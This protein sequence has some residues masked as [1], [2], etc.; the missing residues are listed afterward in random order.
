MRTRARASAA[1]LLLAVMI[2]TAIPFSVSAA[3]TVYNISIGGLR[4][5]VA[6]QTAVPV[7]NANAAPG[8]P[9]MY[10][11]V[12]EETTWY[13][14]AGRP[15]ENPDYR[16]DAGHVYGLLLTLETLGDRT[17][18][19][20][21]AP[22][23]SDENAAN[24]HVSTH[25]FK[26]NIARYRIEF[27][28]PG[29]TEYTPI[30]KI[31]LS[32]VAAPMEGEER[33]YHTPQL[34]YCNSYVFRSSWSGKFDS[35]NRFL[36]GEEYTYSVL[37]IAVEGYSF[38]ASDMIL[39][40]LD[41]KAPDSVR[42]YVESG[43]AYCDISFKYKVSGK[44]L[45]S[46]IRSE[47][48]VPYAGEMPTEENSK[49]LSIGVRDENA[50][51]GAN[52]TICWKKDKNSY[53]Y[54]GRFKFGVF[55]EI[56][57]TYKILNPESLSFTED[58]QLCLANRM[59]WTAKLIKYTADSVTFSVRVRACFRPDAGYYSD[60][61]VYCYSFEDLKGALENPDY[62]YVL[63]NG[64][65]Y[66]YTELLNGDRSYHYDNF[67]SREKSGI[68]VAGKKVL[69]LN[70]E[71]NFSPYDYNCPEE[72]IRVPYG[73]ELELN[74][75]GKMAF[76][77]P[78]CDTG[79]II[80]N[81]G[82]TTVD[83]NVVLECFT[84]NYKFKH[85]ACAIRQSNYAGA[86]LV[87]NNGLFHTINDAD[88]QDAHAA[89]I[90]NGGKATINNGR[91]TFAENGV[92]PRY[93]K[94]GGIMIGANAKSVVINAGRFTGIILPQGKT[95][96]DYVPSGSL[97][98][99]DGTAVSANESVLLETG[100]TEIA[101]FTEAIECHINT[102]K[103]GGEPTQKVYFTQGEATAEKATWYDTTDKRYLEPGDTFIAG[104]WY[105]VDILLAAA[106]GHKFRTD[107]RGD[108]KTTVKLNYS[109]TGRYSVPGRSK[110]DAMII[111]HAAMQC[112]YTVNEL[113]FTVKLPT[114][115]GTPDHN[116]VCAGSN[117]TVPS[118]YLEWYD[119]TNDGH[120][121]NA[122]D[123]FINGHVY[124]VDIWAKA[125]N[126]YKFDETSAV[127]AKINDFPAFVTTAYEQDPERVISVSLLLNCSNMYLRHMEVSATV[128]QA[129]ALPSEKVETSSAYYYAEFVQILKNGAKMPMDEE[130]AQGNKYTVQV[131]FISRE[132]YVLATDGD[133]FINGM[134][135]VMVNHSGNKAVY[136]VTYELSGTGAAVP[137]IPDTFIPGDVNGNGKIDSADYAMCKRAVLK[138]YTLNA[139]QLTRADINKNGKADAS[140]YAMIKRHF[141]KTYVIPGAEGK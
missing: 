98:L 101:Q 137:E 58:V 77:A 126:G 139:D 124:R 54:D 7:T 10:R 12:E 86:E 31:I 52:E 48:P 74:G 102:P 45:V 67:T 6:G 123:K 136:C 83:G 79:C 72:L 68:A 130:F 89:V 92:F 110:N 62:K 112:P 140:E 34:V 80:F 122:G 70:G 36:A 105:S 53:T 14:A 5:P 21:A 66:A 131:R 1:F 134:P 46:I 47:A 114:P 8:N 16:F 20:S 3:E 19:A 35:Q 38:A 94:C 13:D 50:Y 128:P 75:N 97:I 64:I 85:N 51:R 82:K 30:N 22:V 40:R 99:R 18:S 44:G 63:L 113:G 23:L 29:A 4:A 119:V 93:S 111:K 71:A 88:T 132:G 109:V 41:G 15:I 125:A 73:A 118:G 37:L 60:R 61:P 43:S 84:K 90:V 129:G 121:M 57:I 81:A 135:A 11:I 141:L 28:V 127:T 27:T 2:F 55:Y 33:D 138:T 95:I 65:P 116:A 91:F 9:D 96:G 56:D 69:T 115:N 32:G 104:H 76:M 26:S 100:E 49:Y 17:F 78:N 117:Y 133:Y 87:I 59:E 42:S 108:F 106:P 120:A 24:Y 103:A 39:A 25:E 107:A